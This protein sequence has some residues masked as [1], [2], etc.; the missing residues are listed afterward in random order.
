MPQFQITTQAPLIAFI[1]IF[2]MLGGIV[3]LLFGLGVIQS[4]EG[5]DII[6]KIRSGWQTILIGSAGV[7]L[8]GIGV[9]WSVSTQEFPPITPT[10]TVAV[11]ASTPGKSPT[12]TPIQW[13]KG[14]VLFEDDFESGN[15]AQWSS[16]GQ[17]WSVVQ[18][19]AGNA[20]LQGKASN[21]YGGINAGNSTWENYALEAKVYVVKF[22]TA[23]YGET[24][25]IIFRAS[26]NCPRYK[27]IVNEGGL[28]LL[29]EKT[30]NC[31]LEQELR[32]TNYQLPL[33]TWI[34]I[35]VEVVDNI[36]RGYINDQEMV[37][38]TDELSRLKGRI[39]F[40]IGP[41]CTVW[42]DDVRV[43]QLRRQ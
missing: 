4:G 43:V 6:F 35:R 11:V 14:D 9:F 42:F 5:K 25:S 23:E 7:I 12:P 33:N 24:F 28:N 19:D 10:A 31:E 15:I 22:G 36:I 30:P 41:N 40:E 20:V 21:D 8:G 26:N 17:Q 34:T 1:S 38:V 18:N 13:A 37:R 2:L 27:W 32:W 39:G 3:L 16:W 29:R